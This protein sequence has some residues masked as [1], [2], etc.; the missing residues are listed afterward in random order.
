MLEESKRKGNIRTLAGVL[1]PIALLGV[2]IAISG[3]LGLA[4]LTGQFSTEEIS[5]ER[6]TLERNAIVFDVRNV[7]PVDA[8]IET[9]FVNDAIWTFQAQPGPRLARFATS[10]VIVPYQWVEG[11]PLTIAILTG[12]SN[13]RFSKTIEIATLT[14]QPSLSGLVDLAKIGTIVGIIPVF[15]GLLWFP[16]LRRIGSRWMNYLLGFTV[17][18]LVFLGVESIAEAIGTAGNLPKAFGGFGLVATGLAGTFLVLAIINNRAIGM[19]KEKDRTLL[20]TIAYLVS[21]G[22]GLHNL[23]E[24]LAIGG[25]IALGSITLGTQLILGFTIHNT[26]EGLAIVSPIIREPAS[27]RRLGAMGLI[28]GIPTIFGAWIGG[29]IQLDIMAVL[30]LSI[31]AG[32]ILEVVYEISRQARSGLSSLHGYSGIITGLIFMYVTALLVAA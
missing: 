5:I 17:G 3:S 19:R 9:V 22:I 23:G 27:V 11:E 26:T 24:G 18:L 25:A 7:G 6:M 8:S 14:P 21:L 10:K 13:L 15:L 1:L 29:F 4:G 16:F 2:V 12:P 31:G 28:A 20:F 32:A 30:F